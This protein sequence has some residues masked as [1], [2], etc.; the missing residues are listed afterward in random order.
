[1]LLFTIQ[2]FIS[3]RLP[4]KL[5]IKSRQTL[6]TVDSYNSWCIFVYSIFPSDVTRLWKRQQI[7]YVKI[8]ADKSLLSVFIKTLSDCFW[9]IYHY[10]S[11][12]EY[13]AMTLLVSIQFEA[14]F[15]QFYNHNI[16]FKTHNVH[17]THPCIFCNISMCKIIIISQFLHFLLKH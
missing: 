16:S 4:V 10:T 2:T 6:Q 14:N 1:M 15:Q 3:Q 5:C 13:L 7:V 11:Y 17:S 8:A 12:A 9:S